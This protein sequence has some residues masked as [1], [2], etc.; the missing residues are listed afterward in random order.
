MV[1]E[2]ATPLE[3]MSNDDKSVDYPLFPKTTSITFNSGNIVSSSRIKRLMQ[4]HHD[5]EINESIH[6][7]ITSLLPSINSTDSQLKV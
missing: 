6:S 1:F 2:T 4:S 3:L 5:S 7:T